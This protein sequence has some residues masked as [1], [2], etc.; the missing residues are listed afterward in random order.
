MIHKLKAANRRGCT[1]CAMALLM[2]PLRSK[3]KDQTMTEWKGERKKAVQ[4][5]RAIPQMPEGYY[6]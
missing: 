1:T 5:K 3:L 4:R 2:E 6:W